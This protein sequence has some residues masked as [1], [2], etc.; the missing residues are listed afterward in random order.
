M[1]S[2]RHLEKGDNTEEVKVPTTREFLIGVS[3]F[4]VSLLLYCVNTMLIKIV[5]SKFRISGYE[6]TYQFS[7]PLVLIAYIGMRKMAPKG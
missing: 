7:A 1:L 3:M 5:L 2:R 6:V 4:L